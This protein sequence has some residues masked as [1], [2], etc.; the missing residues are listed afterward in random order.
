MN[1]TLR[2]AILRSVRTQSRLAAM[3]GIPEPRVS[4]IV[5]GWQQPTTAERMSIAAA[6]G[7][8]AES[9]F[10]SPETSIR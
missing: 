4:R 9:L 1:L 6:V 10:D 3:T 5:N 2:L 7:V 8:A